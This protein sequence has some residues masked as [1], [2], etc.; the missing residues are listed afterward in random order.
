[1]VWHNLGNI[2]GLHARCH[3]GHRCHQEQKGEGPVRGIRAGFTQEEM[4]KLHLN[5]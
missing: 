5:R 2:K 1:M 4:L 3:Q